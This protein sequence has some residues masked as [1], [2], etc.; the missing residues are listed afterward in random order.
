MWK[1]A[2]MSGQ[3]T[4]ANAS[5]SAS[6]SK[7]GVVVQRAS[8]PPRWKSIGAATSM[9]LAIRS[10][11]AAAWTAASVPPRQYPIRWTRPVRRAA[12]RIARPR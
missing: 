4:L 10:G 12:M 3:G 11:R 1:L 7:V 9:R 2:C 6:R 8:S 5:S